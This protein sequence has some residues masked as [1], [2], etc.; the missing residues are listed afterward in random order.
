MFY[1]VGRYFCFL[2]T[3]GSLG[4]IVYYVLDADKLM[5]I[6]ILDRDVEFLFAE[7]DEVCKLERA[8]SKVVDKLSSGND[9]RLVYVKILYEYCFYLF[10]KFVVH[11]NFSLKIICDINKNL[12]ISV[13]IYAESVSLDLARRGFFKL[14]V[15]EHYLTDLLEDGKLAVYV[16]D[17][18]LDT[19]EDLII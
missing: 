15:S 3:F 1:T 10:K 9:L 2:L 14:G 13:V 18:F 6:V 19:R 4:K 12:F 16:I 11:V 17:L 7:A 8:D 5:N